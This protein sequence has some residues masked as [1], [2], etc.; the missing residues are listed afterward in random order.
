[1]PARTCDQGFV[2]ISDRAGVAVFFGL[3]QILE[4]TYVPA[5]LAGRRGFN[6]VDQRF[7]D[8]QS[9][10][11][12]PAVTVANAVAATHTHTKGAVMRADAQRGAARCFR[13]CW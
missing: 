2:A 11:A 3:A 9:R 1:M 7:V 13:T 4:I 12:F 6:R 8:S 5:K 10:T